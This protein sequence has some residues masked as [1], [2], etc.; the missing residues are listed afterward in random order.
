MK[1]AL[2]KV[3]LT[4]RAV[5]LLYARHDF[6]FT[7]SGLFLG[8]LLF[9]NLL[10]SAE[11]TIAVAANFRETAQAIAQRLESTS[12]H[13]FTIISGSTG[14]LVSQALYGAPFDVVMAADQA[15]PLKL[16]DEG[17]AAMNARRTYALGELGLWWPGKAPPFGIIDLH[18]LSPQSVCLANP[19]LAPYGAAAWS[20]LER[21][22][23]NVEWL[24]GV[25]RVDN[26]NLVAGMV[27]Q[28]QSRAGFVARASITGM[29]RKGDLALD[30]QS[31]LWLSSEAAIQQ[32]LVLM[33]RAE[34]NPAAQWWV[35]QLFEAPIQDL[36]KSHGYQLPKAE[37]SQ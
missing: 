18:E 34:D 3:S 26:V 32:D 20:L 9:C 2:P 1:W 5:F 27:A 10:H 36:L 35:E 24:A 28:K 33:K 15:R 19:A 6:S 22:G 7:R 8:L 16:I 4:R 29:M 31:I 13:R 14:K 25:V 37:Q 11:A 21:S 17:L 12:P 30:D 23:L